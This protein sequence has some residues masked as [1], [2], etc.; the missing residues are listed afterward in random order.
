MCCKLTTPTKTDPL[1]YLTV[2]F[3]LPHKVHTSTC[4]CHKRCVI[5]ELVLCARAP[6]YFIW[7]RN[8]VPTITAIHRVENS[9]RCCQSKCWRPSAALAHSKKMFVYCTLVFLRGYHPQTHHKEMRHKL[10][11]K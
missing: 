1:M 9:L 7:A 4:I 10:F 8:H 5:N 11:N 6:D 2:S 3:N